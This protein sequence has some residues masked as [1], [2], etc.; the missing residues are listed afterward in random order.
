MNRRFAI[1]PGDSA[2]EVISTSTFKKD[3]MLLGF[4][5]HM[6]LRGKDFEYKLIYPDGKEEIE[7]RVPRYDFGWQTNYYPVEPIRMPAGTKML[8][9]AHF[10]NSA[11]NLSNPD[12]TKTV[13]WGDQTWEEMMIGWLD[14]YYLDE[15]PTAGKAEE[16]PK[17][18]EKK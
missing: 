15:K 4:M 6:H 11:G 10:D 16:K 5:P 13:Y 2:H 18:D 17:G 9:T 3:A 14:Y 1:P 7:L 12:A 8:C